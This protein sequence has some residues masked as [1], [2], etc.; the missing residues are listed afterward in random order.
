MVEFSDQG[1]YSNKLIQVI[2][3]HVIQPAGAGVG[4]D[5][6]EA[7]V[8]DVI[9]P[10]FFVQQHVPVSPAHHPVV[11]I[12]DHGFAVEFAPFPVIDS[13]H[14]E[15]AVAAFGEHQV[16]IGESLLD[17]PD[18][19]E[20][21]AHVPMA[22][23]APDVLGGV[24]IGQDGA[25]AL[26]QH[27][28]VVV[29]DH[30]PD[31]VQPGFPEGGSE[32]V[33][34][35]IPFLVGGVDAGFPHLVGHGFVLHG[36]SPD[37]DPVV[38]VG[39]DEFDE[40]AGP[41]IGVARQQGAAVKHVIVGFHP[42]GR[43][44]G[45]GI[46]GEIVARRRHG[47]F[48]ERDPVFLVR[49]D[50]EGSEVGVAVAD[51]GVAGAGEIAAVDGGPAQRVTDAAFRIEVGLQDFA[52]LVLGHFIECFGGG[53][54]EG[55]T[56]AQNRLEGPAGIHEHR[57][58]VFGRLGQVCELEFPAFG[59]SFAGVLGGGV[60]ADGAI[61]VHGRRSRRE[62]AADTHQGCHCGEPEFHA[63]RVSIGFALS[64]AR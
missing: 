45:A 18:I 19:L 35:E 49:G 7:E 58:L 23:D 54:G 64:P 51:V 39:A 56:D 42:G 24:G 20:V 50:A 53:V 10:A 16:G 55:A 61:G 11:E 28:P 38:F 41:R 37:R 48:D 1:W 2:R 22:G 30:E 14:I 27:A 63:L 32:V 17:L 12:V 44:P 26:I 3:I 6:R 25:G 60:D 62:E 21:I 31:V 34:H 57:L 13:G 52:L 36:Q 47:R 29:P 59:E 5:G 40:I 8:P 33:L 9:R 15:R 43:T 4:V 46:K